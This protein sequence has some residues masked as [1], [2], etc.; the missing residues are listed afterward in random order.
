MRR[1]IKIVLI[2]AVLLATIVVVAA[3]Y[4]GI[5][6]WQETETALRVKASEVSTSVKNEVDSLGLE[7]RLSGP[8]AIK[9]AEI[10]RSNLNRIESAKRV[11]GERSSTSVGAV[12]ADAVI[13]QLGGEM[14]VCPAGG[15]YTIGTLETNARCSISSNGNTDPRDDHML[16]NF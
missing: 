1:F 16:K 14:P 11:V 12:D 5:L 4:F 6:D 9:A 8:E 13:R 2:V 15:R 7:P 3:Y 10:C